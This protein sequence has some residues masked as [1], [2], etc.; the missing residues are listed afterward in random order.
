MYRRMTLA[1]LLM[2]SVIWL[3]SCGGGGDGGGG[4]DDDGMDPNTPLIGYW[5]PVDAT[6][7]GDSVS[8]PTALGWDAA[9]TNATY[10]FYQNGTVER[11]AF[12]QGASAGTTNGQW[13]TDN[14]VGYMEFNGVRTTIAASSSYMNIATLTLTHGGHTYIVRMA[15][16]TSLSGHDSEMVRTWRIQSVEVDG[17]PANVKTFFGLHA[18]S[19]A[20]TVQ[21]LP[22]GTGIAREVKGEGVVRYGQGTWVTGGLTGIGSIPAPLTWMDRSI[23]DPGALRTITFFNQNRGETVRIALTRWAPDDTRSQ[24]VVGT[25]K[26]MSGTVNGTAT[27]VTEIFESPAGTTDILVQFWSDGTMEERV[28]NNATVIER[29]LEWWWTP[30]AGVLYLD[31]LD[32]DPAL[33]IN[34]AVAG[35]TMSI[36]FTQQGDAIAIQFAKQ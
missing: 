16:I 2:A 34:Y 28:M 29:M 25:W 9:W 13:M 8:V 18:D 17:A 21:L 35:N 10:R 11:Q 6:E 14:G 31:S 4:D 22:N 15:A 12:T 24:A 7:G 33:L 5:Q 20:L 30:S 19:D 27:P 32:D 1:A 3:A 23:I 26:A 36:N